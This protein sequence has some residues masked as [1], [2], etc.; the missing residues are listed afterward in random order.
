MP[1]IPSG[2]SSDEALNA[3]KRL[4]FYFKRQKGSH[5]VLKRPHASDEGEDTM[6]LVEGSEVAKFTL[7]KNLQRANVEI[8]DFLE[9][10]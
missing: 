8:G 4:G 6:I 5:L 3:L 1:K 9:A 2:I 10:L 7:T